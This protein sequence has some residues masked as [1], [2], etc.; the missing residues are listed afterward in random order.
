[1]WI[2]HNLSSVDALIC[3]ALGKYTDVVFLEYVKLFVGCLALVGAVLFGIMCKFMT[4]VLKF[5]D[6]VYVSKN[7]KTKRR[8]ELGFGLI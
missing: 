6:Y 5:F 4:L 2:S 1:M 7:L 8:H 3:L